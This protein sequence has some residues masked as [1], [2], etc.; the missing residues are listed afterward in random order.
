[1]EESWKHI[2]ET[3]ACPDEHK[4][5]LYLQ[6]Q[7]DEKA[8]FEVEDHLAGC[9]M[10]NDVIEGLSII[11][12]FEHA[13]AS[14]KE[15]KERLHIFLD[16][17]K[18][19]K[20]L[21]ISIRKISIAAT[22]LLLTGIFIIYYISNL[23][24]EKYVTSVIPS[25]QKVS[26]TFKTSVTK[27]LSAE[28]HSTKKEKYGT[29]IIPF[30]QSISD[31]IKPSVKKELLAETRSTKKEN[32]PFV[33]AVISFK[34]YM[35][36][37]K[38]NQT[39]I[40][41]EEMA[42]DAMSETSEIKAE[43]KSSSGIKKA[44]KGR[45]TDSKGE[46]LPGVNVVAKGTNKGTVTDLN[47]NYNINVDDSSTLAFNYVGYEQKEANVSNNETLDIAM[48]EDIKQL[49]EVVV[50]GYG[51][52]KKS[53]VTGAI[54]AIRVKNN[55][56]L[57]DN[58]AGF[59][60]KEALKLLNS[61][62]TLSALKQMQEIS[63]KDKKY[64]AVWYHLSTIYLS[65]YDKSNARKSLNKLLKFTKNKLVKDKIREVTGLL[66]DNKP[67]EALSKLNVLKPE[68]F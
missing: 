34:N 24:K 45:V 11:K 31:T 54:S 61:G 43:Y 19:K 35:I 4:L 47:G 64:A 32:K 20:A 3:S 58:D 52:Q 39:A 53:F 13:E 5:W 44:I 41:A 12:D 48:K 21:I 28:T 23:K 36:A 6:N 57:S 14:A 9:N 56:K 65:Q 22:I 59:K 67:A 55:K 46:P 33:K 18:R 63:K 10:C 27:E 68:D 62:D 51:V 15:I 66:K 50:V 2:I 7:L 17:K 1:L 42:N 16:K 25:K 29:P 8:R 60:L 26:D 49:D 38:E 40:V 37:D 30:K